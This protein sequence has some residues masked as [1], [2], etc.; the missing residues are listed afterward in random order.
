MN[1]SSNL[2]VSISCI[3][4]NHAAYIRQAL[5]G[6]LMQKTSFD[7][8][9]LIHDDASTD[10]TKEII[11][12]YQARFPSIIKPILQEENQYQKGVRGISRNFNYPRA[13]GKYIALCEGDD[14]WTD[15]NKLQKQVDFLEDNPDYVISF[16]DAQVINEKGEITNASKMDDSKKKDYSELEL[17]SGSTFILT[18]SMMFRNLD[19]L[20]DYPQEANKIKNGDNFLTTLLGMYG[21][22]KYQ[23]EIS[24]AVYRQHSSG[25]WTK[26]SDEEK[27]ASKV[28]SYY[29]TLIF[30]QRVGHQ[31]GEEAY[32]NKIAQTFNKKSKSINLL[33]IKKGVFSK[34]AVVLSNLA[35]KFR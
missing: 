22:G 33:V 11:Q 6:F 1:K 9:V 16:H 13:K 8:E 15:P 20:R 26:M 5:D 21:K 10:G 25:I 27:S 14:Y 12:E 4:Y 2:M 31:V 18:L 35:N 7:F 23:P 34:L 32:L 30:F 28:L 29:W 24:P 3:T 17:I 19:I